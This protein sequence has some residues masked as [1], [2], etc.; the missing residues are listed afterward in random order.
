MT[1]LWGLKGKAL[2]P[3]CLIPMEILSD[4]S[5]MS[6]LRTAKDSMDS[7]LKAQEGTFAEAEKELKPK[8]LRPIFV[9]VMLVFRVYSLNVLV[10]RILATGQF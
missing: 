3:V 4:L 7:F 9:A 5:V 8:G 2:C 6:V 10:E 1:A